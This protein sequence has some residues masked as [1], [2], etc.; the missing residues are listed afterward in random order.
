MIVKQEL[1]II[2]AKICEIFVSTIHYE[3]NKIRHTLNKYDKVFLK[4]TLVK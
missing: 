3:Y 2:Q 4:F 1:E